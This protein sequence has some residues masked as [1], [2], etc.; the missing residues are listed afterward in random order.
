MIKNMNE[1]GYDK[2]Y[3]PLAEKIT[4][5]VDYKKVNFP[6]F[7][8]FVVTHEVGHSTTPKTINPSGADVTTQLRR[9]GTTIEEELADTL[10]PWY[11]YVLNKAG[12]SLGAGNPYLN[13]NLDNFLTTTIVT[14]MRGMKQDNLNVD[15]HIRG[16][17]ISFD[18]LM[19]F[20][21]PC[22]PAR[23]AVSF[24]KKG[25]I[26]VDTKPIENMATC[27]SPFKG[28]PLVIAGIESLARQLLAVELGSDATTTKDVE[29]ARNMYAC[30]KERLYGTANTKSTTPGLTS[31]SSEPCC[32]AGLETACLRGSPEQITFPG[33]QN[34]L[35]SLDVIEKAGIP[36]G[37]SKHYPGLD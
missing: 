32:P 35:K 10:S 30:A 17:A 14:S 7:F 1:A 5:N 13:V 31:R 23:Y 6:D 20:Q 36:G 34:W 2:R 22:N 37:L 26:S 24:D 21:D 16:R 33:N 29:A 27:K 12:N 8:N 4:K 28:Q 18:F 11:A 25:I 15:S 3:A 19:N 9:W